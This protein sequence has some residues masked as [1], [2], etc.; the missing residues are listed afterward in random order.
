[1]DNFS[2]LK[3]LKQYDCTISDFQLQSAEAFLKWNWGNRNRESLGFILHLLAFSPLDW[4]GFKE[5][6][7]MQDDA[8]A[9][10]GE[11]IKEYKDADNST[12]KLNE[13]FEVARAWI[14]HK[15]NQAFEEYQKDRR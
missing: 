11:L 15:L 10:L 12:P 7:T 1:M 13:I 9:G 14:S 4:S 5:T 8:L 2:K 3:V 6:L